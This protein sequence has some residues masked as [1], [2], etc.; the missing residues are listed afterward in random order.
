LARLVSV[1]AWAFQSLILN[2]AR[3]RLWDDER[4]NV[5]MGQPEDIQ[6]PQNEFVFA[7]KALPFSA[8]LFGF[9]VTNDSKRKNDEIARRLKQLRHATA[10]DQ[11]QLEGRVGNYT[12]KRV[13]PTIPDRKESP[14]A[15]YVDSFLQNLNILVQRIVRFNE[16]GVSGNNSLDWFT[17]QDMILVQ[18]S[19]MCVERKQDN[20]TIQSFL[21][22][23]GKSDLC[24]S[25]NEILDS[26]VCVD[27]DGLGVSVWR[28]LKI[29]RD[30][31]L[32]HLDN[33]ES[34]SLRNDENQA[35]NSWTPGD[36]IILSRLLLPPL[37][38]EHENLGPIRNLAAVMSSA[39]HVEVELGKREVILNTLLGNG[40]GGTPC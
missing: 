7:D 29:L 33:H 37:E 35:K 27:A 17:Y 4:P 20:Y 36:R 32:C 1:S 8:A 23:Q 16:I 18:T 10:P 11:I 28:A 15:E 2:S 24:E 40:K 34:Y 6:I 3:R 12:D 14:F 19:A 21:A 13:D 26:I 31:F 39:F 5:N 25:I 22:R 30:R 9:V 38:K